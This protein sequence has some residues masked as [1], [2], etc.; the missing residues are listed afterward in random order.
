MIWRS[1]NIAKI[2]AENYT[3]F[4]IYKISDSLA[5]ILLIGYPLIYPEKGRK[6]FPHEKDVIFVIDLT[7]VSLP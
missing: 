1:K 2:W 4:F 7:F 5:L 6:S 3:S